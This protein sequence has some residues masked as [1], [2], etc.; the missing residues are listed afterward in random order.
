[1]PCGVPEIKTCL[2]VVPYT[3]KL[4]LTGNCWSPLASSGFTPEGQPS[5]KGIPIGMKE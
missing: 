5:Q 4:L 3:G 2:R 1:M